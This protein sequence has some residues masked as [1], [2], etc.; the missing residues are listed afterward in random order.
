LIGFA[1]S[2]E[3]GVNPE[4]SL[5]MRKPSPSPCAASMVSSAAVRISSPVRVP[6]NSRYSVFVALSARIS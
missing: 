4:I 1:A 3:G 2:G 6:M 5:T